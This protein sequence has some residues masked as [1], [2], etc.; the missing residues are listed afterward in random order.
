MMGR[1]AEPPIARSTERSVRLNIQCDRAAY[2]PESQIMQCMVSLRACEHT[3]TQRKPVD[4]V[5]VLDKSAS[6]AGEKLALIQQTAELVV[7]ECSGTIRDRLSIITYDTEVECLMPLAAMDASGKERARESIRSIRAGS[8]TNLSGGLLRGLEE[9]ANLQQPADNTS[10][11][12]MT[13]GHAN[14]GI[15]DSQS[16]V[17]CVE[18]ILAARATPCTIFTFG[19]GTDHNAGMLRAISDAGQ[20]QYYAMEGRDAV[21]TSF[22]DALG[23]LMSIVGQNLR[24]RVGAGGGARIIAP[25]GKGYRATNRSDGSWEL[26]LGD[27]YSEESRDL[28][29]EVQLP[30]HAEQPAQQTIS[31]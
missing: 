22:A 8:S 28:L 26:A 27:L 3:P 24:L 25:L 2:T 7:R 16:L 30:S 10:V 21:P 23:G 18:G 6:M 13:D 31:G 5:L 1:A 19:M 17:R 11:F 12:L 4:L 9:V 15:M 20:G 14:A 29:F